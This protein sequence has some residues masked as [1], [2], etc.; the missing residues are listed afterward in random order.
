MILLAEISLEKG[1]RECLDYSFVLDVFTPYSICFSSFRTGRFEFSCL[2]L[3]FPDIIVGTMNFCK[4]KEPQYE[5]Q[6][7]QNFRL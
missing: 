2:V 6:I 3:F 4:I 5:S 1:P 7:L